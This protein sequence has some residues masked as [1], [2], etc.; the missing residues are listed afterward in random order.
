MANWDSKCDIAFSKL[1]EKLISA[2]IM[3]SPDWNLP[4][5]CHVD[6]SQLA[7]GGTLTQISENGEHAI[8]YFSKRLSPE[9]E[10]YSAND[11]ELLGLIYFLKRFRCYLEGS[12]FE[13]LTDNQ[14]LRSFF[15]KPD[16][17]RRDARW[18]DFLGQ[19]GITKMTLVKG[20]IHVLGDALSR[21][22]H[23]VNNIEGQ[24]EDCIS[25]EYPPDMKNNY[26]F[27]QYF[28]PFFKALIGNLPDDATK[29]ERILR[30]LPSFA[31]QD[32]ILTFNGKTCIPRRNVKDTM[33]LAHDSTTSGHFSY[34]KTLA[35]LDN[36]HWKGKSKDIEAY[37]AGC[38]ICQ[39]N[40]DRRTKPFGV[41]QP[42]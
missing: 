4:F 42:L 10:N 12:T 20:K 32:D 34:S 38:M 37:C 25:L 29:K 40:K 13:V 3:Q 5:R 21:A 8:S 9:E 23:I 6:A 18:L 41:P 31:L 22:P 14:V 16:P 11:R 39:V 27:D 26:N 7:V 2:P 1:K 30:L 35:R 19:F 28:S 36:F 17:I 33:H 15:E 24:N